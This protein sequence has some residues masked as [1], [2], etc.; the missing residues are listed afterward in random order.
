MHAGTRNC[1]TYKVFSAL[2]SWPQT[3][4]TSTH[5]SIARMQTHTCCMQAGK[6]LRR[7][8]KH[9]HGCRPATGFL[10][11]GSALLP[12]SGTKY[13][14]QK[15][16]TES[17]GI[18][19]QLAFNCG[20]Y[21]TRSCA[22]RVARLLTLKSPCKT[23]ECTARWGESLPKWIFLIWETIFAAHERQSTLH[24]IQRSRR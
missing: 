16:Q 15:S 8:N 2:S 20:V 10:W 9:D 12:P 21:E 4:S 5:H 19:L 7:S 17:H 14:R 22:E 24:C 1:V 13:Q 6:T 18:L 3:E 11:P 23:S